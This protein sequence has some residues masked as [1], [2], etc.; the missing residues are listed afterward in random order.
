MPR[1]TGVAGTLS[2]GVRYARKFDLSLLRG[3]IMQSQTSS[4]SLRAFLFICFMIFCSLPAAA[5]TNNIP[6]RITQAVDEKNLVVL[7]GNVHP[8]ARP[9]FD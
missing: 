6:A 4:L 1:P 5:Q 2:T 7:R 9:E 3:R 8:L